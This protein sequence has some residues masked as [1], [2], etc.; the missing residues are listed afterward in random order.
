MQSPWATALAPRGGFGRSAIQVGRAIRL[1]G[2]AFAL[3]L[4]GLVTPQVKRQLAAIASICHLIFDLV[5]VDSP[6]ADLTDL[7]GAVP[8]KEQG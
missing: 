8:R 4:P 5:A 7:V 2:H 6:I 1:R 3:Q